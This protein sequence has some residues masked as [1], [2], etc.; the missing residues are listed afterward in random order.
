MNRVHLVIITIILS[1][2]FIGCGANPKNNTPTLP[3]PST[4]T[5]EYGGFD[6]SYDTKLLAL[7]E[8]IAPK[9]QKLSYLDKTTGRTME[10][11]L[12][13]PKNYNPNKQYPLVIFM[14]DASTVGKGTL[15][16]LMQG[17]GGIIWATDESQKENPCF[18]LVPSYKGP[19]PVT[20]DKYEV[21]EEVH[22]TYRLIM[23]T[24]SNYSI[25]Q[26]RVYATG[27]SMGGMISFYLNSHYPSLFT[28]SIY[29]GT[30]W[31]INDLRD[32]LPSQKFFYISS[33]LD[34]SSILMK[35]MEDFFKKEG[36]AYGEIQFA[37]NLPE[38]KKEKYIQKLIKKG[39]NANIVRFTK[40][41]VLPNGFTKKAEAGE[42]MYAFD[43]AFQLK[44]V[45]NWLFSQKKN[46][47]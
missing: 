29:A 4:W 11:N 17:Y 26:S 14:A 7:R 31:T 19:E 46:I 20:N 22:I 10:Y 34:K 39:Y 13:I 16:P 40:G 42:H 18:V 27:Q 21:T 6:K 28:A 38:S 32:V 44:S 2:L 45:R 3:N 33:E 36:I 5:D 1:Y 25:D 23:E 35:D 43:Y 8:E 12:F 41:T 15:A 47:K 24:L 37:A 30:H 9:F